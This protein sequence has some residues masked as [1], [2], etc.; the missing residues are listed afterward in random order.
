MIISDGIF[1]KSKE[2]ISNNQ[3]Q[4]KYNNTLAIRG[5][6]SNS[7]NNIDNK[8]ISLFLGHDFHHVIYPVNK[9]GDLNFIAIMKYSLPINEQKNYSLFNDDNFVKKI[10]DGSPIKIREFLDEI[11]DLKNISSICQ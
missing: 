8:N 1:S 10:L 6:I 2:L 11:K 9:N 5:M 4:P 3:I 7:F